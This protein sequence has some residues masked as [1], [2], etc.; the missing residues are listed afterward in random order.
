MH[1]DAKS[2]SLFHV[3]IRLG[4]EVCFK[5]S[6]LIGTSLIGAS[7]SHGIQVQFHQV[8][9]GA[10]FLSQVAVAATLVTS[11]RLVRLL[12]VRIRNILSLVSTTR[13]TLSLA[14]VLPFEVS[15]IARVSSIPLLLA[16]SVSMYF[17]QRLS[18]HRTKVG[19]PK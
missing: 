6:T 14:L 10:T 5:L 1:R 18:A 11:A 7:S 16:L 19:F 4:V 9:R 13:L 15:R 3:D 12:I 8:L 17:W 2:E